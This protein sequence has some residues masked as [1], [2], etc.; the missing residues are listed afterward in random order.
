MVTHTPTDLRLD[1]VMRALAD[2]TRRQLYALIAAQPGLT[3]NQL[4]LRI[5]GMS[6]WG[7]MKHLAVLRDAGLLLTMPEGR[8]RRHYRESAP[9]EGLERWLADVGRLSGSG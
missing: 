6:R 7:V 4:A 5:G 1:A 2:P 3:T 9:L 8:R